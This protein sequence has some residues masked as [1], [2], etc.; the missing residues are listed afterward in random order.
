MEGLL[1][2]LGRGGVLVGDGAGG[3][4]LARYACGA[5]SRSIACGDLD[6]DRAPD[7]LLAHGSSGLTVLLNDGAGAFPAWTP[8]AAGVAPWAKTTPGEASRANTRRHRTA[9]SIRMR[10]ISIPP[11]PSGIGMWFAAG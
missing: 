8:Y 5:A 9:A 7:L 4:S 11:S 3:F 2:R 6:G 1:A 10:S